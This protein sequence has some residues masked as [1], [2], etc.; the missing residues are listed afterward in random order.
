MSQKSKKEIIQILIN[1]C[2]TKKPHS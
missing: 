1:I 2:I